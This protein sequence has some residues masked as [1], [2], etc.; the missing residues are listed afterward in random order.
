MGKC[1]IMMGLK[2]HHIIFPRKWTPMIVAKQQS[3]V[4]LHVHIRWRGM[5]VLLLL[6][7]QINVLL[8]DHKG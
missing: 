6:Q 7:E 3:I 4:H 2:P 8:L 1:G 5:L